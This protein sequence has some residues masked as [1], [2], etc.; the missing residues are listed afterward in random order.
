MAV[1]RVT[2]LS[3]FDVEAMVTKMMDAE[4]MKLTKVQQSRQ[5]KVWEQEAYRSITDQLNAFKSEY[6]DVLKPD[7]NFRSSSMFAK[8]AT[9]VTVNGTASTAVSVKGTAD[10]QSFDMQIESITQLATKDTYNS[11]TLNFD[12]I[13]SK[14]FGATFT[15]GK[16]TTF[17]ATLAIG[18]TSKT[19]ELNMAG[20]NDITAFKDALNTEIKAEFGAEYENIV[21][22]VGNQIKFRSAGNAVSLIQQSGYED[23]LTWLGV[24]SGTNSLSYQAKSLTDL[25]GVTD[26]DLG[27]MKINGKSLSEIG[28][29]SGDSILKMT[30]KV[31]G[32]G[33]GATISYD[34]LSDKLKVSASK[35]GSANAINLSTELKDK[36]KLSS[37]THTSAQDAV[38][39]MSGTTVIKSENTFSINGA[40][41]TLNSQHSAA[42]GPIKMNFKVDTDK[43]VDKI[44]SFIEVYNGLINSTYGKLN[45][46]VYRSYTPLTE[47]QKK[48]MTEDQIKLWEDKSKSGVLRKHS[49]VENIA[50]KMRRALSDA[51][52]GAGISLSQLGIETSSN[53][54]EN[55]KLVITDETKLRKGIENNYSDVVRLFSSESDKDYLDGT[56]AVERYKE[57]GLGNRLY[58]II[59]DAVRTTRDS[60]GKKGTLVEV[61]GLKNDLSSITSTLSKK[62]TD[63]DDKI[64]TLLKYLT[65][66]ESSYYSTFSRIESAIAKM[67]AQSKNIAS[68][69]GG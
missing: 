66:K 22:T 20:V 4:K 44:K 24:A 65:E 52:E 25:F 58:D 64:T 17:K 38:F 19:I 8:F 40:T 34:S 2:G 15:T 41:I 10:L 59:Q 36:L 57:N 42:S 69:L 50:L 54:K 56:N 14:D 7:S 1:N 28:V 60:N 32:A 47:D 5:Y 27:N 29:T 26:T 31:N 11:E 33:I 45:E 62:I 12:A 39:S 46:K 67:E 21:S 68:Q 35:E 55:G 51:V 49:D 63:Y 37:G 30:Q 23:S 13:M 9:S 16:P 48:E 43:V 18:S 6:F 53:Y 3:N 61:A